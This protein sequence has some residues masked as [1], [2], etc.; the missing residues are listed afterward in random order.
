MSAALMALPASAEAVTYGA[1]LKTAARTAPWV[2][3]IWFASSVDTTPTPACAG[4]AIGPLEVLTTA[5]CTKDKGFYF[6]R[7]GGNTLT[8]G[9]F[10]AIEAINNNRGFRGS[11]LIADISLL[12]PL[13][14]L[15]LRAYARVATAAQAASVRS[16]R[17]PALTL[18]GW[19]KNAGGKVTGAL[20]VV[21]VSP[22]TGLAKGSYRNFSPKVQIA[23]GKRVG[24]KFAG[25]C[26]GDS[27]APLIMKAG[28]V[29]VVVGMG[30]GWDTRG[31]S[32][33]PSAFTSVGNYAAWITLA[34]R[35]MPGLAKT[36][37][38]ALPQPSALPS[39]NGVAPALGAQVTCLTGTWSHNTTSVAATWT[40]D[41]SIALE[42][43][44]V[45]TF[46]AEDAGH[47][48]S[49]AVTARSRAGSYSLKAGDIVVPAAPDPYAR[50]AL[51]G[52][53]T[54]S[55]LP[56]PGTVATCTGPAQTAP[57]VT[58][59]Y[60][61]FASAA[62]GSDLTGAAL[63]ATNSATLTLTAEN[64]QL[65]SPVGVGS[66][67]I[68]CRAN[69]SN[70]MGSVART[71]DLYVPMHFTPSPGASV[72]GTPKVGSP[73]TCNATGVGGFTVSYRWGRST[74]AQYGSGALPAA[75]S[76]IAGATTA[77]Y[78][79]T[80]ADVNSYLQCEVTASTW[81]GTGVD[82]DGSG[83]KTAA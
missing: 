8:T 39:L 2:V 54:D 65:A 81:Y 79:P 37:N 50:P 58:I 67:Y 31:C 42:A 71:A 36:A 29:A 43:G 1:P 34:R 32:V 27:G 15:G 24:K 73:L 45:H 57:G 77:T 30:I 28:R 5:S 7:V 19:G 10:I 26:D 72:V 9:H 16:K 64:L 18:Y 21:T 80:A 70:A 53:P 25:L 55:S 35:A 75:S 62:G 49:C 13:S 78:T 48:V 74:T 6:V 44:A 47:T 20:N 66:G 61:W 69:V 14:P 56:V 52:V 51:T 3:A 68:V 41:G 46:V 12:R 59:T 82:Y 60:D 33:G 11:S 4:T 83:S 76:V 38:R 23:A 17:P 40:R 63:L 22:Q